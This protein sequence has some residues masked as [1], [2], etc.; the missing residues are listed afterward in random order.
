MVRGPV[1]LNEF[2]AQVT[3]R[4]R[5]LAASL[6]PALGAPVAELAGRPAK[7]IRPMLVRAC[8][9]CGAPDPD[10]LPRL[11]AVVE[12][13]HLASLLHDDMIDDAAVRRGGPAAHVVAGRELTVLA[14]L[15]CFS[16]AGTEAGDLG[17]DVQLLVG[18]ASARLAYGELLDVERAFDTALPLPDYLELVERKT[19]DLFRLS[20]LLGAAEAGADGD[21]AR[22]LGSFGSDLGV[23]FQILDDCLDL[24][25]GAPGKPG[26]TDHLL[27]LFGA[28]T[29]VALAGEVRGPLARLL[30]SP[31]F[32]PSDLPEVRA[33]VQQRGGLGA[34]MRLARDRY[35][36]ALR[37]LDELPDQR[38]LGTLKMVAAIAWQGRT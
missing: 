26:G 19:G 2:C 6:P 7:L 27:G 17:G 36:R 21:I 24:E 5:M 9:E 23:A 38:A 16:L 13:L 12:L 3:A 4:V 29:L 32:G 28:P 37:K 1:G 34:A 15:A 20:C 10:R 30:L 11:G 25:D 31:S 33:Q 8:A 14:G 22:S 35:Q 18:Q